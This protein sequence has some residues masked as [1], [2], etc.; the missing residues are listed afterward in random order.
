MSTGV[1]FCSLKNKNVSSENKIEE[2]GQGLKL[3]FYIVGLSPV[4]T[5]IERG[6]RTESKVQQAKKLIPPFFELVHLFFCLF[7]FFFFF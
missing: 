5:F 6:K 1:C 4:L 3:D 2:L 7:F